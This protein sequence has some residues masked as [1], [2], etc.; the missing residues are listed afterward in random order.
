MLENSKAFAEGPQLAQE[1]RRDEPSFLT[2]SVREVVTLFV[3]ERVS[4]ARP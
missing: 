4:E 3:K 2:I 1:A